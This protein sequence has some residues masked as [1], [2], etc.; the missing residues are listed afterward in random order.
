MVQ[1]YAPGK[2]FAVGMKLTMDQAKEIGWEAG[3][4]IDQEIPIEVGE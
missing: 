1:R 3:G 4:R 2:F